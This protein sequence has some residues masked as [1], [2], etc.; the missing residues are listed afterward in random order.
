MLVLRNPKDVSVS[1][2]YH[3]KGM[4]RTNYEGTFA[5]HHQLFLKGQGNERESEREREGEPDRQT[6]NDTYTD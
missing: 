5:D 2:Y 1:F 3:H 4:K 6:D